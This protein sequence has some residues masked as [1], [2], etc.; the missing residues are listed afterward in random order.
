[1]MKLPPISLISIAAL[2]FCCASSAQVHAD[3]SPG[4]AQ[5]FA[6]QSLNLT[7]IGRE[8]TLRHAAEKGLPHFK[9]EIFG[10][11]VPVVLLNKKTIPE[12][13][14]LLEGTMGIVQALAPQNEADH[15][16]I[17]LPGQIFHS[18]IP[19]KLF[20]KQSPSAILMDLF[21]PEKSG[22]NA[23]N[24]N[25]YRFKS[26][27]DYFGIRNHDS[28]VMVDLAYALSREDQ[29][30]V[31]L[32]HAAKRISLVRIQYAFDE[33]NNPWISQQRRV[34]QQ[35]GDFFR[36]KLTGGFEQCN[37]SR[38]GG[39]A[40][41]H[42]AEMR[43]RMW[44]L[45]NRDV[46]LILGLPETRRFL[47]DAK[48]DLLYRNWKN[49]DEYNPDFLNKPHYLG[50]M[51]AHFQPHLNQAQRVDALSYLLATNIFEEVLQIKYRLGIEEGR[52]SQFGN[53]NISA[54]LI[55]AD[56]P[57]A[58]HDFYSGHYEYL[59]AATG[60]GFSSKYFKSTPAYQPWHWP[61]HWSHYVP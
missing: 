9:I 32:Y 49:A 16:N 17:R 61:Q 14:F 28:T 52:N 27:A 48:R 57:S 20:E 50:L 7:D 40:E 31:W 26:V 42:V 15:G 41:K 24:G 54:V 58:A 13:N 46:N 22:K 21:S 3:F 60:N 23:I 2:F 38:L 44:K 1:M 4:C 36:D 5:L 10:R 29:I 35:D 11:Q 59:G 37:N 12:W 47:D 34:L 43:G 30:R 19:G 56:S 45:F 39:N 51:Q 55:Y 53:P 18:A 6:D 25:G 8:R 33:A